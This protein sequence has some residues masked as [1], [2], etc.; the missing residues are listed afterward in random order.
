VIHSTFHTTF[1]VAPGQLVFGRDMLLS[2]PFQEDWVQAKKQKQGVI[3][4]GVFKRD[5]ARCV[6]HSY[7]PV[8]AFS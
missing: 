4:K 1:Q 2:L 7:H 8:M 3:E 5:N 6:T